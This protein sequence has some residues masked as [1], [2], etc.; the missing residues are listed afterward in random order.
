M[1]QDAQARLQSRWNGGDYR[2]DLAAVS[3]R[4]R[5]LRRRAERRAAAAATEEVSGRTEGD[6]ALADAG[7]HV[8]GGI[9]LEATFW[10]VQA[11]GFRMVVLYG[12]LPLASSK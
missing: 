12:G 4:L 9:M 6:G 10:G 2:S 3:E 8:L 7:M 11:G 5:K 1:V